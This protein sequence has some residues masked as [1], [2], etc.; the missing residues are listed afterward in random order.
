MG[1]MRSL[2]RGSVQHLSDTEALWEAFGR[3]RRAKRRTATVAAFDL[4]ADRHVL[5]LHRDLRAG[6]YRHGDFRLHVIRDPKTRF[7]AAAPVRDRV[8]HQALA[9]ELAPAYAPSFLDQHYACGTG[10]SAAS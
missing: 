10:R 5:A 9:T 1:L 8:L 3:V 7:I 6:R 4:E 2:K